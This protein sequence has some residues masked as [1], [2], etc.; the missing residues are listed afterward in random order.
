MIATDSLVSI[1]CRTTNRPLLAKALHSIAQQSHSCIELVLVD[2]IGEGNI[3]YEQYCNNLQTQLVSTGK[4]LARS[5]AANEGLRAA[6]GEFVLFLDDD[7]WIESQHIENLLNCLKENSSAKAAY[8][9]VAITNEEGELTDNVFGAPYDEVRLR[10]DNFMPIHAVLFERSLFLNG[11]K[12]DEEFEIYE[13]WDFWL[14]LSQ[15]TRFV[16]F[17]KVGAYYR[18]G[19]DSGVNDNE[20][21]IK[22]RIQLYDKWRALWRGQELNEIIEKLKA[23][24]A[25]KEQALKNAYTELASLQSQLLKAQISHQEMKHNYEQMEHNYE[26]MQH[27]YIHAKNSLDEVYASFSWRVT[28]PYRWLREYFR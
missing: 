21:I 4:Q 26:Q 19:G 9:N 5:Q 1:I 22:S 25:E 13:D 28:K 10:I 6:R 2:V 14:Q 16:H 8:S 20:I 23:I 27:N 3:E 12:F 11:C 15:H 18:R 17:D 24:S 7:D